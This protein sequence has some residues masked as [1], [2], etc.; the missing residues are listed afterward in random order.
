MKHGVIVVSLLILTLCLTGVVTAADNSTAINNGNQLSITQEENQMQSI[1]N[2]VSIEN[3]KSLSSVCSVSEESIMELSSNGELIETDYDEAYNETIDETPMED[4]LGKDDQL[5]IVE[6]GVSQFNMDLDKDLNVK[7]QK[8]ELDYK[9]DYQLSYELT[10]FANKYLD[11][12]SS[13]D[14]FVITTFKSS[15]INNKTAK[16]ILNGIINA[17]NGYVHYGNGNLLTLYSIYT[18][19]KIAYFIKK[20]E[21]ISLLYYN[22][23]FLL[24]SGDVGLNSD[25]LIGE[26][27]V[28][29]EEFSTYL[30]VLNSWTTSDSRPLLSGILC[31]ESEIQIYSQEIE[32]N[33]LLENTKDILGDSIDSSNNAFI[34]NNANSDE[35][36]Y[37]G[38]GMV[39]GDLTESNLIGANETQEV[40]KNPL[41]QEQLE[42]IG[43]DASKKALN[44]FKSKGIKIQKGYP[45]LYILTSAGYVKV[46]DS[47]TGFVLNGISNT[48]GAILFDN[49]LPVHTPLWEDLVFYFLW[50]DSTD[51]SHYLSYAFVYDGLTNNFIVSSDVKQ[52]GDEF[53]YDLDLYEKSDSHDKKKT[54]KKHT[55]KSKK[56]SKNKGSNNKEISGSK[57]TKS[58]YNPSY[59]A[60]TLVETTF[61]NTATNSTNVN[62][63]NNNNTTNATATATSPDVG[64]IFAQMQFNPYSAV[65]VLLAIGLV[66]MVFSVGYLRN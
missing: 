18:D 38:V 57:T 54:P 4:L 13:K 62:N 6:P 46:N 15:K 9:D 23:G 8:L 59:K 45:Y 51:S 30:N 3:T 53:A 66:C 14:I 40:L 52:Q 25:C 63:T 36:A 10:N 58:Y 33:L 27:N 16:N 60:A 48:T 34:W 28:T 39:N 21:S 42:Q 5:N 17:S 20:D 1:A 64:S 61:F 24:Y 11:L 55:K 44:Y 56:H 65:Y 7:V 2:D 19:Y 29:E 50:V 49:L 37:D 32:F 22:N 31:D 26:F 35:N 47:S 12:T 41:S 43:I